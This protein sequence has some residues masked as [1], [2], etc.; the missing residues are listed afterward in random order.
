MELKQIQSEPLYQFLIELLSKIAN[1]EDVA[2]MLKPSG[3][4]V[5]RKAFTHAS[6]DINENYEVLELLGDAKLDAAFKDFL[7]FKFP[8]VSSPQIFTI[9]DTF[10]LSK[11]YLAQ[12][13]DK[14]H[15]SD[16]II[17]KEPLTIDD[18]EDLFESFL[19]ALFVVGDKEIQ[20]HMGDVYVTEFVHKV[21]EKEDVQVEDF[22][23]YKSFVSVLK[24][25]YDRKAWGSVRYIEKSIPG[26]GFFV[27][28]IKDGVT[29]GKGEDKIIKNAR[30]QASEKAL[31]YLEKQGITTK[32][33]AK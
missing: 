23:K 8:S 6:I 20:R 2:K 26:F 32:R 3:Y 15:L 17:T 1:K 22:A 30:E 21:F 14:Y 10:F 9:L 16:Y 25:T 7:Y 4:K 29:I 13:S 24:E 19:G 11:S 12:L 28:V 33:I 27:S 31:K 5:F 18:K